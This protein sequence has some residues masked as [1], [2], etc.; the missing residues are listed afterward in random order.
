M[1]DTIE[2]VT[3]WIVAG[4]VTLAGILV[5]QWAAE[6]GRRRQE[7]RVTIYEPMHRELEDVLSNGHRLLQD[8]YRAWSPSTEFND[9][10]KRGALVPK[11]HD[12]LRADVTELLR[13]NERHES[14]FIEL[15]N[16]REKAI[17]DK[18]EA[19]DL[20]DEKGDRIRLADLLGHNFSDDQFNQ[21]LTSL[22]KEQWT[23]QLDM[24]V[25]GQGGNR[26]LKLTLGISADDL[27]DEITAILAPA[28]KAFFEDGETLL[29]QVD[30]IK[31]ALE[32]ALK[33]GRVYRATNG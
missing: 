16:K 27:F 19:T 6:R 29:N 13:L 21:A 22:D 31:S 4:L 10:V 3:G 2:L 11:R 12:P 32:Q 18:W 8:G 26:G 9:L 17:R 23:R 33:N 15:Y 5:A 20:E 14:T 24:R 25:T 1:A 30:R 7:D 28:R